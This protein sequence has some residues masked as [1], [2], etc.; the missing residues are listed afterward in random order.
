M[1]K[2]ISTDLAKSN[3]A[4]PTKILGEL[5]LYLLAFQ[6]SP[7]GMVITRIADNIIVEVNDSFLECLGFSKDEVIGKTSLELEMWADPAERSDFIRQL[8]TQGKV[9]NFIHKIHR[10]SSGAG[11]VS[12][13]AV[14]M[15]FNHEQ[16]MMGMITDITETIVQRE[17]LRESE[18]RY[19]AIM[20]EAPNAIIIGGVEGLIAANKAAINLWNANSESDLLGKTPF[21]LIHPDCHASLR[22]R[23]D[24]V[25]NYGLPAPIAEEKAQCLDGQLKHVAVSAI[26]IYFSGV[27][28]FLATLDDLT[29]VKRAEALYTATIL[30]MSEGIQLTRVADGSIVYANP[31]FEH[32][33]GYQSGELV[34]KN[35]SVL[36][37]PNKESPEQVAASIQETLQSKGTWQGEINNIRKDGTKFWCHASVSE[38]DDPK[39]G[40]VWISVHQD[41]TDKKT[42]LDQ[43]HR[44]NE[45]LKLAQYAAGAGVWDW[46]IITGEIAWSDEMFILFGLDASKNKAGFESWQKVVHPE[47]LE[48]ANHRISNSV[49]DGTLLDSEYRIIRP[50]GE[51]RW[52]NAIGR[53]IFD[54]DS[55]PQRSIGLCRDI[56][57]RKCLE[58][59]MQIS[60]RV[61]MSA[62]EGIMITDMDGNIIDI[63]EAFTQ[64]TGYT[65]DDVVGKT[66][67]FLKSGHHE[68]DFYV[69]VWKD[70]IS[71]G[72]WVGE[73][74]NRRKNGEL[75][76]ERLSIS[77]IRDGSS[78]PSH[79]V[80]IFTDITQEKM[81]ETNLIHKAQHDPLTSLPN[82]SLMEDRMRQAIALALREN[83]LLAVCYLDLDEFKPINDCAGH[84]TGDEIL[85]EVAKR[86]SS[87]L[88][89]GDTVARMGG[90]EFAL[91]LVGL[92]NIEECRATLER[93]MDFVSQPIKIN[94]QIYNISAS[95]GVTFYPQ[96]NT[97]IS[98]LLHQADQA[99]YQAKKAGRNR[100]HFYNMENN[101]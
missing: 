52:I 20:T 40:K 34:G 64:I 39:H 88:R 19:R 15:E 70:I 63:N 26:P 25:M 89:M 61:F 79:Y 93:L 16:H 65:R 47:D 78:R 36:N 99:M 60:A 35:V 69:N 17:R 72:H 71:I 86:V 33:F 49:E 12:C 66:P 14:L 74:W 32:M 46:D 80:G 9:E 10:K 1:A 56:T 51:V 76:P 77:A 41:I 7:I 28:H 67:G 96:E 90:D 83:K 73:I 29:S 62:Q 100:Y 101:K 44:S 30:K 97:D 6:S 42:Y 91:L 50:D 23:V 68:A 27:R 59:Q 38:F 54:A 2:Q 85:V 8:S 5:D 55:N 31:A 22:I 57:S 53:T 48:G 92:D 94:H 13:S 11:Y 87:T 4:T 84:D 98:S 21:D 43:L 3:T 18:S 75:F 37:A 82:R 81:R 45:Q 24:Q 95:I 58:A